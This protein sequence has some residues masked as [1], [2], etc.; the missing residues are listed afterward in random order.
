[1]ADQLT[2]DEFA[3]RIKSKYPQ[4]AD[5]DNDELTR[6]IVTKYP[7]YRSKVAL[8]SSGASGTFE[9]PG[10]LDRPAP[11]IPGVTELARFGRS[12]YE[13]AKSVVT[14]T[15]HA[16]VDEPQTPEELLA[17]AAGARAIG[18]NAGSTASAIGGRAGLAISRMTVLPQVEQAEQT[19]NKDLTLTE[20]FGHGLAAVTPFVGPIAADVGETL[21]TEG[22]PE[23]AGKAVVYAAAPKV[24]KA[25]I[26]A[27]LGPIGKLRATAAEKARS[28]ARSLVGASPFKITEKAAEAKATQIEKVTARNAAAEAAHIKATQQAL[29]ENRTAAAAASRTEAVEKSAQKGSGELGNRI[30]DLDSKLR[31]EGNE[32]YS[33]VSEA[34]KDD[35]GEPAA[36]LAEAVRHAETNILKGS[37]ESIKQFRD[38]VAKGEAEESASFGGFTPEPGS[39]A[40]RLFREQGLIPEDA[41]L[42]F[43]QLQ[44]Y[45]SEL[46]AK[47][48]KG[49]LPGDVYQALKYVKSQIDAAKTRIAARN[50]ADALLADADTFWNRYMDTFYDKDSA[51]AK[52][53][54]N[55]GVVDPA[56]YAEPFTKG[57]SAGVGIGKLGQI[58]TRHAAEV[59]GV[60]QLADNL[61][62]F[63]SS[64]SFTDYS[65]TVIST[66]NAPKPTEIP[67][68]P[69]PL[70]VKPLTPSNLTKAMEKAVKSK[71][72]ELTAF[73]RF[74]AMVIA[75]ST[76]G[77]LLGAD[78]IKAIIGG[79]GAIGLEKG[80]G[81]VLNRPAVIN[82]ISKP[83]PADIAALS[84][85]SEPARATLAAQLRT[86]IDQERM[87]GRSVSIDPFVAQLIGG[88]GV[89]GAANQPVR[90]RQEALDLLNQLPTPLQRAPQP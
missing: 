61:R 82:W 78:P 77:V 35:S 46:G 39:A 75:G 7:E 26:D 33:A 43:D 88:A 13:T 56:F 70:T 64:E 48:A 8:P 20:R 83:I 22:L 41:V 12:A 79:A 44:G 80:M 51:V 66:T 32:K 19:F 72:A 87:R 55:V 50:G 29:A 60:Q 40:E 76:I 74:D 84:N 90:T 3:Q 54:E 85:L 34:V 86:I 9:T 1:M 31:A 69:K 36:P 2:I 81:A 16:V 37:P 65:G 27:S 38:I 25:A 68:K 42:P 59:A 67:P 6:R 62:K 73:R 24:T 58:P 53:R 4:Y 47:L 63:Q 5:I 18:P 71:S 28:T 10:I 52:V 15:Y 89:L 21:G 11:Y 23:A 57:K 14:G 30:S 49:G 17:Y 45:S